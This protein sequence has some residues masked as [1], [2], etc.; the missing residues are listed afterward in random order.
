MKN[1]RNK[2]VMIIRNVL[3]ENAAQPADIRIENGCFREIR[4]GLIPGEN[5]EVVD[6]ENHL[7][8]PPFIE[9][10]IHLDTCLTAGDPCWN[11][12][13]TLFEGISCWTKRKGKL[14]REDTVSYTH[15]WATRPG[16][17]RQEMISGRRRRGNGLRSRLK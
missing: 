16:M 8:L 2:S 10:H 5:E 14:S 6:G 1:E 9:S 13:G 12:S 7:L 4:A 17:G 15:L 3:I 11:E